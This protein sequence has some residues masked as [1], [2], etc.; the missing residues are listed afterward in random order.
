MTRREAHLWILVVVVAVLCPAILPA[1]IVVAL[2]A[3]ALIVLV[4]RPA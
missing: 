4:M 3:A 2:F 1:P